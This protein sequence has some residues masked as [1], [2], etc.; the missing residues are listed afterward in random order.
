MAERAFEGLR[1]I[2]CT[3]GVSGPYCTKLMADFGAEVIKIEKPGEGDCARR[4]GPFLRDDPHPEKSVTFF[5]LNTNK[6]GITLNLKCETG[7]GIFKELIRD[8]DV[9]VENLGPKGFSE[10]GLSY[11][12]LK[13]ENPKLI[14]TSISNFGQS[15]PYREYKASNLTIYGLGG[16]MYTQ[17]PPED[18][19]DRPVVEGGMQAEYL[20]GLLSFIATIASLINRS[21][22]GRGTMIDIS[23]MECVAS[24]LGAHISEYSYIGLSRRTNPWPIHGY[25]IGYSVSCRDGWISLTPGI[26]GAPNIAFL[27]GQ[28]ELQDDPLFSKPAARMAEPEKFDA[29]IHSYLKEHDKWEITKEAQELRLAF[30]PVL[31]PKELLEDEQL[32]AREVFVKTNHPLMGEVT[33]CGAPAKLSETPWQKGRAPLLGEHNEEIYGRLGY[34]K[35]Q[36]VRLREQGVI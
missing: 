13:K 21:K 29:L 11:E 15:G 24:S 7:I 26:G 6:K 19:M 30:T 2:D 31:S 5:Y 14:M 20:T 34:R 22:S 23:A 27:I 28:P 8:G 32:K 16:T 35:E 25:P 17:R 12:I 9:L 4:M 3:E 10:I 18:P 1:V 33:Y 36:I